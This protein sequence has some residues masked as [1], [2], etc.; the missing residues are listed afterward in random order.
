MVEVKETVRE[1]VPTMEG[2]LSSV[3]TAKDITRVRVGT[4]QPHRG[5]CL[6]RGDGGGEMGTTTCA[7]ASGSKSRANVHKSQ[8]T[9]PVKIE[10]VV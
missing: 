8:G 5:D 7:G 10:A 1:A 9:A 4:P 3:S 6:S 2:A